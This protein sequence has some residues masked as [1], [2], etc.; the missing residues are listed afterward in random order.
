MIRLTEDDKRNL[1]YIVDEFNDEDRFVRQRQLETWKEL[2]YFWDGLTHTYYDYVAHDWRIYDE[3]RMDDSEYDKPVNIFRAYLESIIAALS[4]TIPVIKC[5]PEDADNSLD[6]TTA[7]A[8]DKISKLVYRQNDIALLWLHALFLYCTEGVVAA[9]NYSEEDKKYGTY[10]ENKY[11]DV[12]ETHSYVT[13][14]N[15]GAQIEDIQLLD[16]V[17]EE[18]EV[19][20]EEEDYCPSC[21]ELGTPTRQTETL[22]IPKLIGSSEKP[23]SQP[24]IKVCG[25]LH[26][27]IPN[28]AKDFTECPYLIYKHELHY[29]VVRYKYSKDEKLRDKI[30]SSV[31]GDALYEM[32]ARLSTQYRGSD[33]PRD[34]VTETIAWLRPCAFEIIE[35][36]D[37][38]RLKKLF[39]NGVKVIL[40]DEVFAEAIPENMDDVWTLTY[41]PLTDYL[42]HDPVGL[43]LTSYEEITEMLVSLI[44]QT[45]E[46]G[47]PQTVAD[48]GVLNFRAYEKS[49]AKPG[50]IIPGTP[51]SGRQLSDHFHDIKTAT[52]SQ[53]VLPFAQWTQS[54]SQI[55]SGALPSLFGGAL[56]GTKTASEYNMSRSQ[57]LQRQQNTWKIFTIWWK[58]IFAKVI[59]DFMRN[60][61]DDEKYVEKDRYG[62]FF[63]VFIRM[64]ELEGKIGRV[65]LEASENLPMTWLQKRDTVL[66]L[67]QL[68]NPLIIQYLMSPENI[69][70]IREFIG[71]DD[72]YIPGEDD[73]TKQHEEIRLLLESEPI[74]TGEMDESGNEILEP[75]VE[76]DPLHDNHV[77]EGEI[78]RIWITS[79]S[80]RLAKRQ[81]RKGYDNV[82]LH[83][84]DHKLAEIEQAKNM[85]EVPTPTEEPQNVTEQPVI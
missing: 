77:I 25:G 7:K 75:S 28:Y 44:L 55:A 17:K 5:Y 74:A 47:I 37:A 13:C 48:P 38:N 16:E 42:Q 9:W 84:R 23:K 18:P 30:A 53:E 20:F 69:P 12:E 57:A 49:S 45:I 68:N 22:V 35:V 81:N 36:E 85:T 65:E 83:T 27:K 41:N 56:E 43:I 15:C 60:L 79:E 61:K 76:V 67:F 40:E 4:V 54:L 80:G 71:L 46:H 32:R 26:V 19:E 2:K 29:S 78:C 14:S 50:S 33:Y 24:K 39:P 66:Q 6:L 63:N 21:G 51:K 59:P 82:L 34:L 8:G 52:L 73:R 72:A 1:K 58:Q 31:S 64:A 11:E 3:S 70:L 62:R 10:K